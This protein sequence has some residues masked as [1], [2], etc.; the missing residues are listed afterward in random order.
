MVQFRTKI[1]ILFLALSL[2]GSHVNAAD[3]GY[4]AQAKQKARNLRDWSAQTADKVRVKAHDAYEFTCEKARALYE[5][6]KEN[7]KLIAGAV[8]Y[9]AYE[10]VGSYNGWYTP[11]RRLFVLPGQLDAANADLNTANQVTIP[12]LERQVNAA[13]R[14]LDLEL[15]EH[16][17]IITNLNGQLN[18]ARVN[19]NAANNTIRDRNA[20]LIRSDERLMNVL[21]EN[22]K[23]QQQLI[24]QLNQARAQAQQVQQQQPEADIAQLEHQNEHDKAVFS[25]VA[26]NFLEQSK[27]AHIAQGRTQILLAQKHD[28]IKNEL[29]KLNQELNA[30]VQD[31]QYQAIDSVDI[32]NDLI[33]QEHELVICQQSLRNLYGDEQ[34]GHANVQDTFATLVNLTQQ[35]INHVI[36]QIND[37]AEWL[38]NQSKAMDFKDVNAD[39][40]D[41]EIAVVYADIQNNFAQMN[42]ACAQLNW[43][44]ERSHS[45]E[46]INFC[47]NRCDDA[48]TKS[49][50]TVQ[51]LGA[52]IINSLAKVENLLK[53]NNMVN[54]HD[55]AFNLYAH[56]LMA[57][58]AYESYNNFCSMM[59]NSDGLS[60]WAKEHEAAITF[61]NSLLT[62]G[63]GLQESFNGTNSALGNSTLFNCLNDSIN[64]LNNTGLNRSVVNNLDL[65]AFLANSINPLDQSIA[66]RASWLERSVLSTGSLFASTTSVSITGSTVDDIDALLKLA[67]QKS[68]Q[69]WAD[70]LS[71]IDQSVCDFGKSS[72]LDLNNSLNL[73]K[74][75]ANS[76]TQ[77]VNVTNSINLGNSINLS[78]SVASFVGNASMNPCP[79]VP[80]ERWARAQERLDQSGHFNNRMR[81]SMLP[82]FAPIYANRPSTRS[83]LLNTNNNIAKPATRAVGNLVAKFET[84]GLVSSQK[85]PVIKNTPKYTV[86]DLVNELGESIT[87]QTNAANAA[88]NSGTID[89]LKALLTLDEPTTTATSTYHPIDYYSYTGDDVDSGK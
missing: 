58:C 13:N 5:K 27:E 3:A 68:E 2:V 6:A 53:T 46:T 49:E 39:N 40:F 41:E 38:K 60:D 55:D 54:S 12:N 66:L 75:L 63:V 73:S 62:N 20:D 25:I 26:K 34:N 74:V 15:E 28:G 56:G 85:R 7:K 78:D 57:T 69:E 61:V 17:E 50:G 52:I 67:T 44:I 30:A 65:S 77:S 14:A 82:K 80:A 72:V 42:V 33:K 71:A 16:D 70:E 79:F 86:T 31:G 32:I 89:T 24:D 29:A 45:N 1:N 8:A 51:A 59:P 23:E 76:G 87:P 48:E 64:M 10:A 84:D 36:N 11:L 19:L 35:T 21:D 18:T 4:V 83:V 81:Y 9:L 43:I 88:E 37:D 47:L 22:R